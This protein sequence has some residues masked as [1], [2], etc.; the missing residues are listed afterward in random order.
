ME[1]EIVEALIGIQVVIA[2]LSVVVAIVGFTIDI[3]LATVLVMMIQKK[4][5]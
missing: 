5:E 2:K 4:K 1:A 3:V